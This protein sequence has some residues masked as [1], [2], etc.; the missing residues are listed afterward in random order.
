[1]S[2]LIQVLI[3]EPGKPPRLAKTENTWTAFQHIVGGPI[4]VGCYLPQQ[5]LLISN[6]DAGLIGLPPNR[7]TKPNGEYIL[8]TFLLCGFDDSGYTSLSEKQ[9]RKFTAYFSPNRS[10]KLPPLVQR[11]A[12]V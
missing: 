9:R 8:G 6:A 11:K 4:E 12:V 10:E 1:M 3:V 5:V 2:K 7:A